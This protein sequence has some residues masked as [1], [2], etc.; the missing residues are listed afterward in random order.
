M[1]TE[2]LE[3]KGFK[4]TKKTAKE[5]S[6]P[7]PF[8][9]GEDRFC[10]WPEENRAKCIRGCGWKGDDIQLLRDLDGLSFQEAAEACGHD[11]KV[12]YQT[13][14]GKPPSKK[15]KEPFLHSTMGKPDSIH[16]Y[17]DE[18]GKTLFCVCR[19][20]KK[21]Q[22]RREDLFP[23]PSRWTNM[24]R[25]RRPPCSSQPACNQGFKLRLP[26]GRGEVC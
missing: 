16:R 9:G 12:D 11:D 26:G 8:C 14:T 20:E 6:S 3:K 7:C 19:F 2:I 10:V 15:G 1:L 18:T 23:V 21:G 24:E 13:E 5:Y 4:L 25:Q 17:H 22:E